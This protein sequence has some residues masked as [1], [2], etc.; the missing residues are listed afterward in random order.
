M[1][2]K[3]QKYILN[4]QKDIR[5]GLHDIDM[6]GNWLEAYN[7]WCNE[8]K[9]QFISLLMIM[10]PFNPS[11]AGDS[12]T[13][14]RAN[15]DHIV[16]LDIMR[17]SVFLSEH[18]MKLSRDVFSQVRAER[19]RDKKVS[20]INSYFEIVDN[21]VN[22]QKLAGCIVTLN[23]AAEK[24]MVLQGTRFVDLYVAFY[25]L[26]ELLRKETAESLYL[27]YTYWRITKSRK[28]LKN[29]INA[30]IDYIQVYFEDFDHDPEMHLYYPLD[31]LMT[32]K[33]LAVVSHWLEI[34]A[35]HTNGIFEKYKDLNWLAPADMM[36]DDIVETAQI[37]KFEMLNY[38]RI[39]INDDNE[40]V[41]K[42]AIGNH[43]ST[44]MPEAVMVWRCLY[45]RAPQA[46]IPTQVP[47]AR[48]FLVWDSATEG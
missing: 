20:L 22:S 47:F 43:G 17:M 11:C 23:E 28:S 38:K 31:G 9:N 36:A 2:D 1:S 37:S 21:I 30:I 12:Y 34:I 42:K 19:N 32:V 18:L 46:P 16:D 13:Y 5:S 45:I 3:E 39:F 10:D 35:F 48:L 33:K 7:Q 14:D 4:M 24:Q 25:S 26:R 29:L 6:M 8:E 27:L 40:T 44:S 41:R 15:P